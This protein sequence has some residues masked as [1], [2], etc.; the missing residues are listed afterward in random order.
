MDFSRETGDRGPSIGEIEEDLIVESH[1]ADMPRFDEDE[2]VV[3]EV[4]EGYA[5]P[6]SSGKKKALIFLGVF[7]VFGL[8]FIGF[9]LWMLFAPHQ[10][11]VPQYGNEQL[12]AAMQA[13]TNA[14]P[15]HKTGGV[16]ADNQRLIDTLSSAQSARP[17]PAPIQ[18]ELVPASSLPKVSAPSLAPAPQ[19]QSPVHQNK[20]A[21]PEA[22]PKMNEG[23]E[24]DSVVGIAAI[25]QSVTE[26][27]AK[28]QSLIE[29]M[30]SSIQQV[31]TQVGD[32]SV[33]LA[34]QGQR[35]DALSKTV[36]DIQHEKRVVHVREVRRSPS[37]AKNVEKVDRT[38]TG[39]T[40]AGMGGGRAMVVAPDGHSYLVSV[41]DSL[42]K[43]GRVVSLDI[44]HGEVIT[45]SAVIRQPS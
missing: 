12:A 41:G 11:A 18:A 28:N 9:L 20:A 5:E 16:S 36:A 26:A 3:P 40:L 25:A 1:F 6:Q 24:S 13:S 27:L 45:A 22:A 8:G 17:Q 38:E 34:K 44:Q 42:P 31:V 35:I 30:Q 19:L 39:W 14:A 33:T 7:G 29:G 37:E 15:A 2:E 32:Q 21:L 4:D 23:G 10:N 43:L